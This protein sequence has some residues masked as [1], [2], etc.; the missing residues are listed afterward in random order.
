MRVGRGQGDGIMKSHMVV[1]RVCDLYKS[2][3]MGSGV[4]VVNCS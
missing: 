3:N 1:D 4:V 2:Q